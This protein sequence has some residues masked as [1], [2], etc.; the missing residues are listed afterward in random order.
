MLELG[1]AGSAGVG[2]GVLPV[3]R[4]GAVVATVRA[5]TWR[6]AAT[7]VVADREWVFAKARREIAGR[8]AADPEGTAR[9][10]ARQTSWWKGTWSVDLE[11][12]QLTA[13]RP[14]VWRSGLRYADGGQQVATGGT[15]GTWSPLPTLTAAEALPLHQQVFLLWLQLVVARRDQAVWGAVIAG[16]A[17]GAAGSS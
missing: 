8:W 5:A 13:T 10:R 16:G 12:R 4:D 3:L 1:R 2:K 9:L 7:A 15:T 17:A 14:S 6:E 11:G